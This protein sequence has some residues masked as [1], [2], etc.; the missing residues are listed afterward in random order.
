MYYRLRSVDADGKSY[1][2]EIRT[3]R[4]SKQAD[5]NMTIIA[6]PN[7]VT[8]ELRITIPASWQNRKVT[9]ELIGTNGQRISKTENGCSNQTE[10]MNVTGLVTGCYIISVSCDGGTLEQKII[11]Q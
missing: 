7:P 8:N 5:S 3:I 9:Y 6:Y 11:K 4:I 1:Y 2:S 10:T